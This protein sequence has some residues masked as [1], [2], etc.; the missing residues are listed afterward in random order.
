[1]KEVRRRKFHTEENEDGN[2]I[3]IRRELGRIIVFVCILAGFCVEFFE[4]GF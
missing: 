1:M 2:E 4:I 3:T